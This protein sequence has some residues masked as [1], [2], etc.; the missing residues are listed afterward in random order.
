MVG[1]LVE[2]L[3]MLADM[4]PLVNGFL[5]LSLGISLLYPTT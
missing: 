5:P 3:Q 2:Q 4:Q 1:L